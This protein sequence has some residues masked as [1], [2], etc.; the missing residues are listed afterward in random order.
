MHEN[1]QENLKENIL[2]YTKL[3]FPKYR[4]VKLKLQRAMLQI[5]FSSFYRAI[6]YW[7]GQIESVKY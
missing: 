6:W 5:S 3:L 2:L 7:K 1:E 4:I